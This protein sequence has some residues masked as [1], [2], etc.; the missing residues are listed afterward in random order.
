MISDRWSSH[1]KWRGEGDMPVAEKKKLQEAVRKAHARGRTLR[2]WA[3]PEKTSVWKVLHE[4][5][6]DHINTDKLAELAAFLRKKNS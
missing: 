1:F 3:T 5:G 4:A 6:V 2:F